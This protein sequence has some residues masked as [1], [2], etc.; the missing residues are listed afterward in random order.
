MLRTVG[1]SVSF[2]GLRAVDRVD[3]EVPAGKLVGLIGPN[4]AG[5]TTM[6]DVSVPR[7]IKTDPGGILLT[8]QNDVEAD[9]YWEERLLPILEK[10]PCSHW[11][12]LGSYFSYFPTS[13]PVSEPS[14][15]CVIVSG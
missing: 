7:A 15:V 8:M 9:G 1:L 6:F 4:G 11:F 10:F 2:G 12:L 5:K 14:C 3:I 13:L